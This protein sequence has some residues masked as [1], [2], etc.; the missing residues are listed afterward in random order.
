MQRTNQP[1]VR[2]PALALKETKM[3]YLRVSFSEQGAHLVTPGPNETEIEA[4]YD[5]AAQAAEAASNYI[6]E[7]FPTSLSSK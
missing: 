1:A 6:L 3:P 5:N 4:V 2:R 7:N